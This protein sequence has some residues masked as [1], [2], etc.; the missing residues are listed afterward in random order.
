[1]QPRAGAVLLK[2]AVDLNPDVVLGGLQDERVAPG[3]ALFD[4]LLAEHDQRRQVGRE[5]PAGR[6]AAYLRRREIE[7]TGALLIGA[8]HLI[9]IGVNHQLGAGGLIKIAVKRHGGCSLGNL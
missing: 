1:M 3:P 6:A 4:E 9:G 8:D 2:A 5:Q 7:Q